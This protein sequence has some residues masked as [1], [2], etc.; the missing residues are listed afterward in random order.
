[1]TLR[2]SIYLE[3]GWFVILATTALSVEALEPQG[4][5]LKASPS[6]VSVNTLDATGQV[7]GSGSG[8]VIAPGEV[9]TNYH[10]VIEGMQFRV[11]KERRT[12]PAYVRFHDEAR[13]L[14]FM[15]PKPH[16]LPVRYTVLPPRRT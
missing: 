7:M 3:F 9:I 14:N 8:V 12:A 2:A 13:D 16:P 11:K 1:M 6:V 5:F 10:V 4:V 15:R